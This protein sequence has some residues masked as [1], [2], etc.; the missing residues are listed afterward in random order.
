MSRNGYSNVARDVPVRT[1]SRGSDLLPTAQKRVRPT[2]ARERC[3]APLKLGLPPVMP[4]LATTILL[5]L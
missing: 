4:C 1:L 3:E 2:P 5:A